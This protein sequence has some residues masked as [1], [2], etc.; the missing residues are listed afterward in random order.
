MLF[1]GFGLS[2]L[3]DGGIG[4]WFTKHK[5]SLLLG[6]TWE[7]LQ[8]TFLLQASF[9]NTLSY[10]HHNTYFNPASHTKVDQNQDAG[11]LDPLLV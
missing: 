7:M 3:V 8:N 11:M 5:G 6:C 10:K 4:N 1:C 9:S 2:V